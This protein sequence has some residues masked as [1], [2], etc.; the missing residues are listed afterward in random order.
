MHGLLPIIRRTRTPLAP[1]ETPGAVDSAP[2]PAPGAVSASLPDPARGAGPQAARPP[3]AIP[4]F[5]RPE[6]SQPRTPLGVGIQQRTMAGDPGQGGAAF[7]RSV[8]VGV[9]NN[10][11]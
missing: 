5:H 1:P 8:S 2:R 7:P 9:P 4:T 10:I 3:V 11:T 6:R